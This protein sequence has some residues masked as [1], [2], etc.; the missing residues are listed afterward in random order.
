MRRD[1]LFSCGGTVSDAQSKKPIAGAFVYSAD[2][3]TRTDAAGAF[4]L[5][6]KDARPGGVIWIEADGYALREY[7]VLDD[8]SKSQDA[9]I[10]LSTEA[11][12]TGQ[13]I[14]PDN[15]PV[16]GA[17]VS[18]MVKHFQFL[19]PPP[20]GTPAYPNFG[21]PIEVRT[22][23]DGRYAFRGLPA[24]LKL[25]WYEVRHPECRTLPE[26]RRVLRAG[27]SNDFKMAAGCKVSGVVVDEAG[28]A[29]RRRGSSTP[30]AWRKGRDFALISNGP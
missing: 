2:T 5:R 6:P 20:S 18:V 3:M 1:L 29:A 17:I 9:R 23:A 21:F 11:P 28:P 7:P 24:G 4:Q 22:D 10:V 19:V 27:E 16:A 13:A 12:I 30:Q 26:R 25:D 14:G 15:R 8:A